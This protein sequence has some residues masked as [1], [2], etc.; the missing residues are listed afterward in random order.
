MQGIRIFGAL[1]GLIPAA[2][3][4]AVFTVTSTAA[5][6]VGSLDAVINAANATPGTDTIEFAI[7]GTGVKTLVAP[8][9]GYRQITESL[10][11]NGYTQAGSAM[12][13]IASDASNARIHVEIDAAAVTAPGRVFSADSGTPKFR[14]FPPD[15]ALSG[16][17]AM[18]RIKELSLLGRAV[19]KTSV[20]T[21]SCSFTS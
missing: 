16:A 8:T 2:A 7:P 4:G 21:R 3:T 1:L 6:G 17:L 10:I 15:F 11:V 5:S 19:R 13:S 12:N 18:C 9:A 20:V 14:T